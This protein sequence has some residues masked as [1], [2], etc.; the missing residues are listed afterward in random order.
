[1]SIV[2]VP[3]ACPHGGVVHIDARPAVRASASPPYANQVPGVPC[4]RIAVVP[5]LP[6]TRAPELV[7][8]VVT[9]L[10]SVNAA[11]H[12]VQ[13]SIVTSASETL[14]AA[15]LAIARKHGYGVAL[16]GTSASV[17]QVFAQVEF[18]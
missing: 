7:T 18:R 15:A 3:L 2:A 9:A 6:G 16:R 11:G 1:V 5:G 17:R 4:V 8:G 10:V 12:A 14:N 13:A